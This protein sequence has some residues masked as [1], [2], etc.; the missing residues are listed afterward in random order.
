M[1]RLQL[2]FFALI[3]VL[4]PS[5]FAKDNPQPLPDQIQ[6]LD[7]QIAQLESQQAT[8][9]EQARQL[10]LT[11]TDQD[12]SWKDLMGQIDRIESQQKSLQQQRQQAEKAAADKA[13]AQT[14]LSEAE[15]ALEAAK[16][17]LEEAKQALEK[18]SKEVESAIAKQTELENLVN[19]TKDQLPEL[20]TRAAAA[21]Q[22]SQASHQAIAALEQQASALASSHQQHRA[23]IQS[24]LEAS[25]QWVSFSNEI[26]PIFQNRCVPCHNV[27]NPQ[28]RYNMAT[29]AATLSDG[30]SGPAIVPGD[31]KSSDLYNYIV[32]GWMPYET[33]PLLPEEIEL[34]GRWIDLGARLDIIADANA[35]LLRLMPRSA[36]PFPP[37]TYAASVP[38]TALAIDRTGTQLA[39]SGYH[40]ILVWSLADKSL[41]KRISNVAQRIYGLDY[42][43]QSSLLAVASGTPSKIGEVKIFDAATGELHADLAISE[44]V[45]FDVA[46]S[47]DGNRLA[48]AGAD[49]SI[50]IFDL[51]PKS[52]ESSEPL[53]VEG[54]ADWVTS[55]AWSPDG[56]KLVTSSRDKTC[57]VFDAS[58]GDLL[59][60]FSGHQTPTHTAIF[61]ADGQQV[62]SGGDDER[63]RIWNVADAKQQREVGG[64]A[65]KVS[66]VEMLGD[67]ECIAIDK[68][69]KTH[70]ISL[71]DGKVL[72]TINNGSPWL[73]ALVKSHD[74]KH[75]YVGN[76]EG[77]IQLLQLE[78]SSIGSEWDSKP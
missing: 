4:H 2:L 41:A 24:L 78:Q 11:A 56:S 76:H 45:M 39:S 25:D 68:A 36:Q 63:V 8:L 53:R 10:R 61:S 20:K 46:F 29:F 49:A 38:V 57:K 43:P 3:L 35:P 59:I 5:T 75:V 23:K 31:A 44:D 40:E 18:S 14:A 48:A 19:Q 32:D 13:T 9:L 60:T 27:R 77:Q 6:Q 67:K 1:I 15:A 17:R 26:A 30:Q 37:S 52:E 65:A 16:K 22:E 72:Q 70:R 12:R 50:T 62:I 69:G 58:T 47:P 74:S 66:Q 28:G 7:E 55:I 51:S 64:F 73:S 71:A 21:E 34:I 54:H 33:D 42:H